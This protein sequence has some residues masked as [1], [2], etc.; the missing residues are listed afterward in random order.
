MRSKITDCRSIIGFR[1]VLIH[2]Y[3]EI[4]DETVWAILQTKLP[5]LLSEVDALMP[6]NESKS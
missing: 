3:S 5:V 6:S 1:N 2:Q 4:D